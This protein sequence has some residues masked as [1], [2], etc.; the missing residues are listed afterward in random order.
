MRVAMIPVLPLLLKPSCVSFQTFFHASQ[1]VLLRPN[2]F[3]PHLCSYMC[4]TSQLSDLL[5]SRRSG[6]S[7]MSSGG[8]GATL[9]ASLGMAPGA[10]VSCINQI[11][12]SEVV[13]QPAPLML[14]IPGAILSASCEPVRVGGYT[15]CATGPSGSSGRAS[16]DLKALVPGILAIFT[17]L[18]S[19]CPLLWLLREP[20]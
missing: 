13:I 8:G 11:P 2:L 18:L 5:S 1:D 16:S 10:S 20:Q 9:A 17:L 6:G 19:R 4:T 15:A 7:M 12:S 3:R 14:T